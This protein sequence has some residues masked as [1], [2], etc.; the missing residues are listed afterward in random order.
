MSSLKPGLKLITPTLVTYTGSGSGS[1]TA[2]GKVTVTDAPSV[3]INGVFSSL[4]TNYYI[5]LELSYTSVGYTEVFAQMMKSGAPNTNSNY[6]SQRIEANSS[7]V[8]GARS[9]SLTSVAIG[10]ASSTQPSFTDLYVFAPFVST[11][12]TAFQTNGV[13]GFDS[14]YLR[15]YVGTLSDIDSYDGIA[16]SVAA[17]TFTGHIQVYGF[18]E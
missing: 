5:S 8:T 18:N 15:D 3:R 16:F 6:V 2:M 11:T 13:N 17:G 12:S 7:S 10:M 14:L 9:G 1:T 4:Y